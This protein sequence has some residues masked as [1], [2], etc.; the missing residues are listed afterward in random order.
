MLP[1]KGIFNLSKTGMSAVSAQ[2]Y[3]AKLHLQECSLNLL[4]CNVALLTSPILSPGGQE[5]QPPDIA[6]EL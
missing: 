4:D 6:T 1:S 2:K 3:G 5:K